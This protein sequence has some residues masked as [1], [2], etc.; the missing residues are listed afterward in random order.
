VP[1]LGLQIARRLN[2]GR[3]GG[4]VPRTGETMM[5]DGPRSISSNCDYEP[6][7]RAIA[8]FEMF[9]AVGASAKPRRRQ[10]RDAGCRE[11]GR[12]FEVQQP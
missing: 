9:V 8:A 11:L 4:G 10:T 3:G 6:A 7:K 12:I 1:R 2:D 5:R